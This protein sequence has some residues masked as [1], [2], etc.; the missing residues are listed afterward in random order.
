VSLQALRGLS[1]SLGTSGTAFGIARPKEGLRFVC[2]VI[3]LAAIAALTIAR[4]LGDLHPL[5]HAVTAAGPAV[6]TEP[7]GC[8]VL[9]DALTE[10]FA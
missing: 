2:D 1:T 4:V 6:F 8:F 10:G 5:P 9:G 7:A 3:Q